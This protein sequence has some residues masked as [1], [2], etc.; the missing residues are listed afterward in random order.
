MRENNTDRQKIDCQQCLSFFLLL[1]VGELF[2]PI[3]NE[4]ANADR[5]QD[6]LSFSLSVY[7]VFGAF[8]QSQS[9][10]YKLSGK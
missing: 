9:E 7:S 1:I 3:A 6:G 8:I 10:L 5:R 2:N 4:N